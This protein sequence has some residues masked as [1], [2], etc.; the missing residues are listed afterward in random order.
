VKIAISGDLGKPRGIYLRMCPNCGGDIEDHFLAH[1]NACRKCM[2]RDTP[3]EVRSFKELYDIVGSRATNNLVKLVEIERRHRRLYELFRKAVG[4]E[5]WS[6]QRMWMWRL[7][8][9]KS[10]SMLAPTGVGKTTFGLVATLYM[11]S[12]GK[13]SYIIVPTSLLVEHYE[14]K[15][16][17]MMDRLGIVAKVIAIHSRMSKQRK[18]IAEEDVIRGDF[19]IL[20]TTSR[21]LIKNYNPIFQELV[22]RLGKI[23]FIFVDD[24]DAVLKGSKAVDYIFKLIG[25]SDAAISSAYELIEL[26]R[27]LLR[28][29]A[30]GGRD[31]D[32]LRRD[33]ERLSNEIKQERSRV[34]VVLISTAT[35]RPRGKRA[36]LFR[37]LLG[38][39]V[40]GRPELYRNIVDVSVDAK[41]A[42]D[43][44]IVEFV[45]ELV[46][47]LGKGGLVFVPVDK[48]IEYAEKIAE[49]L[50]LRGVKAVVASSKRRVPLD[51]FIKGEVE[52]LVGVATYYGVL[53]RGLDL[54]EVIRYAIFIEVPRHKLN[55]SRLEVRVYDMIRLLTVLLDALTDSEKEKA[56]NYL[57]ILNRIARRLPP[58]VIKELE[59]EVESKPIEALYGYT[60]TIAE[61]YSW[62]KSTLERRDIV[63]RLKSLPN[64]SIVEER[65][66]LYILIPDAATYIQASG[67]TS[68]LYAGGI[69]KGLSIVISSDE[70]LLQG[71]ERRLRYLIED[72]EFKNF[73]VENLST[74]KSFLSEIVKQIDED[75]RKVSQIR[76]GV[77]EPAK[78]QIL[79]LTTALM[80][81][82]SPNKARTI[83]SFFGRPTILNLGPVKAY[84]IDI[85]D[86]HLIIVASKGH[87]FDLIEEDI[88]DSSIYG[89]KIVVDGDS[90]RFLPKYYF[91][92]RCPVC[93]HQFVSLSDKCPRCS[94]SKNQ[95]ANE[96]PML[97]RVISAEDVVRVLQDL[98]M[99]VDEV[100]IATDPDAEGEKI[101][102]DIA[103]ALAPFAK[104][105]KRVEFHEVTRRA[106]LE[107]LQ[108]PRPIKLSLVEAQIVRRVE[109]RW[110]GFALSNYV[111]ERAREI[112][113]KICNQNQNCEGV[114]G[115][116]KSGLEKVRLSAGRVQTPTLG[117]VIEQYLNHI[118]RSRL[119]LT[120]ELGTEVLRVPIDEQTSALWNDT[121]EG[122]GI[123]VE[124]KYDN[125]YTAELSPLPPYTTD[126]LLYDASRLLKLDA[127]ETMRIAQ[128]L[129]ETGLITYHRTDSTRVST[130]GI[131]VAEEYVKNNAPHLKFVGRSWGE[132]GAHEAI[133]PTR[134]IDALQLRS[135]IVQGIIE[136]ARPLTKNHL[137]LYDLIFRR[138]I[139]SQLDKAVV[140]MADITV[141]I[142]HA[143]TGQLLGEIK[144]KRVIRV[145]HPSFLEIYSPVTIWSIPEG[146]VKP[147]SFRIDVH[148]DVKLPTQGEVIL[149]MKNVGIGRPS[150]YAKIVDVLIK[151][152]YLLKSKL[153]LT[154]SPLGILV[155]TL[156]AGFEFPQSSYSLDLADAIRNSIYFKR[157]YE[158]ARKRKSLLRMISSNIEILNL[159]SNFKPDPLVKDMVSLN[160]TKTLVEEMDQIESGL[161]SYE[162]TLRELFDEILQVLKLQGI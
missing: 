93:G 151:R 125:I 44:D 40:G 15:L 68:R 107:A 87:I 5:P 86:R 94:F 53:A 59:A 110:I 158:S 135:L 36:Q 121:F 162:H 115:R 19:D 83:A 23:D 27:R 122:N 132:G 18:K 99:E 112:T 26:R 50:N 32:K 33:Y 48:G 13:K 147:S 138:F 56:E 8:K 1:G 161:K 67:R 55:L 17:E 12:E 100:L 25:F 150:T 20:I 104:S 69:T 159:A 61:V 66:Q 108:N 157:L 74:L 140:S 75:R 54:P 70:R 80:V 129:F 42:S 120:V 136:T 43:D 76:L 62:L 31:C 133:R 119:Y 139:A 51:S 137:R 98:S 60:K 155:Y 24:V 145:L 81:V 127:Q 4:N 114:L 106:I 7:A 9:N 14:K 52:V 64:V 131:R 10:F 152:R 156:L 148:S 128:E 141:K 78:E 28:C 134:P 72:F 45:A 65:G 123:K 11:A 57:I 109:D 113:S 38:F 92:K 90:V 105:I 97:P 35:G 58:S 142:F 30:A 82:E 29:I 117:H 37:E 160:K 153:G 79:K 6:I 49:N 41:S 47:T 96:E 95:S 16:N 71:L 91:I 103:V 46:R 118:L 102:Y 73:S 34:G 154:V 88:A 149:W 144:L 143:R 89:V 39:T 130:A 111:T 84:E 116:L 22:K 63:E 21:Y 85:G 101:G 146:V 2:G 77:I 126:A 3:I 124:V